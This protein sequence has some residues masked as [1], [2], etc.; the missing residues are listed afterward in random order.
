MFSFR[1]FSKTEAEPQKVEKVS[2]PAP[3]P[4]H[5]LDEVTGGI[6][7][8]ST[9][10]KRHELV[11]Q[12]LATEPNKILLQQVYKELSARDKGAAKHIRTH[13]NDI[14]KTQ[15]QDDIAQQWAQKAEKI[16]TAN[17]FHLA[18]GM[19]WLRDAAKAGAPLSK[20]PLASL[21]AQI[22]E[23][24]KTLEDLQHRSMVQ[25]EAAVLLAQR[26]DVLSTKSWQVAAQACDGLQADIEK[27]QGM[28][29]QLTTHAAWQHI[30]PRYQSAIESSGA[31]LQLVF[32]AFNHALNLAKAAAQDPTAELP[33]VQ[34][35]ADEL[36]QQHGIAAPAES[37]AQ[38]T[39][40]Q[41]EAVVAAVKA[42]EKTTKNGQAKDSAKAA[43]ALREQLKAISVA[44]PADLEQ[45]INRALID[46]GDLQGWQRWGANQVRE[47]LI[48]RTEGLLISPDGQAP[49]VGSKKLQQQLRDLREQWR[50]VDRS[51]PP[52]AHLWKR[53]DEAA[54]KVHAVVEEWL[55]KVKA[56]ISVHKAERLAILDELTAW[57]EAQAQ[58]AQQDLKALQRGL[59]QFANRWRAAGHVSDK[60]YIQLQERWKAAY[61]KVAAPLEEAKKHSINQRKA[62][63]EEANALASAV[64]LNVGAIKQLQQR[65]QALAQTISI[66]R[67]QEQKLWD[68]FRKPL[69]DAFN[70]KNTVREQE[71][72]EISAHD[73]AVLE[74]VKVLEEATQAGDAAAIRQA[75]QAL[76]Y[77]SR[78]GAAADNKP[79]AEGNAEQAPQ[80]NAEAQTAAPAQ[81][82]AAPETEDTAAAEK[83]AAAKPVIAMR[84]DDR[85][86]LQ[87]TKAAPAAPADTRGKPAGRERRNPTERP[88]RAP[89]APRLGDRAFR[90]QRNALDNAQQVLRKLSSQAHGESLVQLLEAWK[91]RDAS[92]VPATN[93]LSR[94]LNASTLNEW[95]K[96][97]ETAEANSAKGSEALLRLEIAA[98]VPTPAEALADRRSLQ[99]QLLTQK[100]AATPFETWA[101][102]VATVLRTPADEATSK[103]L[104]A[105]LKVLL[106]N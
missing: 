99:L 35:W 51:S 82:A 64:P 33:N 100:N 101:S 93:Q 24:I 32:E 61:E 62:L 105:A 97:L 95:K 63:I 52:N 96:A 3:T 90:A 66:D 5:P 55:N 85:P 80:T 29:N 56:E 48:A 98:E 84:G 25:K 58:N 75:M 20:E 2:A 92:A 40:E 45:R 26:I 76:E 57:G 86:N 10:S 89:A 65:W 59:Q 49:V 38:L 15:N 74:A 36:K 23:M 28:S 68:A 22:A 88:P 11:I 7:S 14:R 1:F 46:A 42:L 53:F 104:Q 4:I 106:R 19:A 72:A 8:A 13:M 6:F 83:P 30:E 31:Q 78:H 37:T 39:P 71:Q 73:K 16:L 54:T 47:E 50:Q 60:L 67:K 34:V 77:V 44:V 103:R 17:Q 87:V 79:S 9:S 12:W 43:A 27:W 70:R 81:E 91:T 69:D 94:K 102:D 21:R 41:Q 18:D